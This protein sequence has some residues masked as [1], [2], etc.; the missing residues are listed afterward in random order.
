M[1]TADSVLAI[2]AKPGAD[3]VLVNA[4]FIALNHF[5]GNNDSD[6]TVSNKC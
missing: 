3:V 5:P 6:F 4:C 1:R 2:A